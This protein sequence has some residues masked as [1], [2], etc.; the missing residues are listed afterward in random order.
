MGQQ[1]ASER[2][3]LAQRERA[4]VLLSGGAAGGAG[5]PGSAT[6]AG[7][8]G[9]GGAAPFGLDQGSPMG[10]GRWLLAIESRRRPQSG[11]WALGSPPVTRHCKPLQS[12]PST[13][14]TTTRRTRA[15][16]PNRASHWIYTFANPCLWP[17][18]DLLCCLYFMTATSSP[19]DFLRLDNATELTAAVDIP[20]SC[21]CPIDPPPDGK[22]APT[23]RG[24][25]DL[26]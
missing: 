4:A 12:A 11:R 5:S 19:A 18:S 20:P 25:G 13:C 22:N 21:H 9:Q 8:A 16:A 3:F 14:L 26:L 6:A 10:T 1:A 15:S 7:S 23:D 2:R 24:R 17:A